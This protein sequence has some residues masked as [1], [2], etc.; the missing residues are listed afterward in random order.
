MTCKL[1]T[2]P[3][4]LKGAIYYQIIEVNLYKINFITKLRNSKAIKV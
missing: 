1:L 3:M 4:N 2:T